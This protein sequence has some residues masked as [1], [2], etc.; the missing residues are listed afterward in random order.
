MD[1]VRDFLNRAVECRRLAA[2]AMTQ[3]IR[4]HYENLARMWERLAKEREAF[5]IEKP[6]A[7]A[8]RERSETD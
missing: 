5:F 7:G 3:E 6:V 1:K 8:G 4:G 2:G